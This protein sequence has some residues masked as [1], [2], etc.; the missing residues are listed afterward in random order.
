MRQLTPHKGSRFGAVA[1]AIMVLGLALVAP[2]LM[3]HHA[4]SSFVRTHEL[5]FR[6]SPGAFI[7]AGAKKRINQDVHLLSPIKIRIESEVPARASLDQ[8]SVTNRS[9][10]P[11]LIPH[12]RIA[13]A[14]DGD[15]DLA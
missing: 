9:V 6:N 13:S 8:E 10:E 7:T 11:R 4:R 1:T 5:R 2:M 3:M 15:P 14:P 12:K